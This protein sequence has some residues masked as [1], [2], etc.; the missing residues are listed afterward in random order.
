GLDR[1]LTSPSPIEGGLGQEDLD[2]TAQVRVSA[3]PSS[4]DAE[5]SMFEG[6]KVRRDQ[7]AK[8]AAL[9]RS[10]ATIE[11]ALD[12]TILDANPNFLATVGY[13]LEE[14]RG[15]HHSLFV[16]PSELGSDAYREFW[17]SLRRGTFASAE[18]KRL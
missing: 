9:S 1:H 4:R 11:F 5:E 10:L 18:Y 14:I 3:A 15:R 8:L 13:T 12:G 16:P 7:A 17:D 2:L 6:A